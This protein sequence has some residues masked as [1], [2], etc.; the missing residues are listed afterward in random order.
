MDWIQVHLALN[1]LPV[2]AIPV[3]IIVLML[4]WWRRSREVTHLSLVALTVLAGLAIAIKFTGDFAAEQSA[5]RLAPIKKWVEAHEQAGDQATTGV[6][7]L[8]LSTALAL[9]LGRK[10]RHVPWLSLAF[11]ALLGVVTCF[12]Y[13]RT[14]HS[15]GK[16]SHPELRG[17]DGR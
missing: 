14:A 6:F 9:F 17:S 11:V 1:H 8:G 16:I 12:L 15:G 5:S 10:G 3:F 4:G 13:L 7:L 2:V